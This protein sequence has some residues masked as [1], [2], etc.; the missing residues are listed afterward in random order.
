MLPLF[1]HH[2]EGYLQVEVM[3]REFPDGPTEHVVALAVTVLGLGLMLY[4][5][6][7]LVRD[8]LRW[9][10]RRAVQVRDRSREDR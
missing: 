5:L 7:S 10:Q 2:M 3:G 8:V 4:G 9:R 1:G 6:Y